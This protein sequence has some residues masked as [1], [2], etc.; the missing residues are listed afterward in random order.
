MRKI[1]YRPHIPTPD[2]KQRANRLKQDFSYGWKKGKRYSKINNKGY[3]SDIYISSKSA[4]KNVKLTRD[5]IPVISA[6]VGLAIPFP[7]LSVLGFGIGFAIK[8]CINI[9][10]KKA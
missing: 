9:I 7:F 4:I 5:D 3:A 10:S 6:L 2:V 1:I 8:K